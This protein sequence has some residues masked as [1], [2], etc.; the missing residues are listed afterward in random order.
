[1]LSSSKLLH[2][3]KP[4]SFR[5]ILELL[6]WHQQP[7]TSHLWWF[8]GLC[9]FQPWSQKALFLSLYEHAHLF[10]PPPS[11]HLLTRKLQGETLLAGEEVCGEL[12]GDGVKGAV[13]VLGQRRA[14]QLPQEHS[15][16][17]GTVP[18]AK[19]IMNFLGVENQE[20][21]TVENI[22]NDTPINRYKESFIKKNRKQKRVW[23]F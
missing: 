13:C 18:Y 1:M 8:E 20:M 9:P 7:K 19:H 3:L 11:F 12:Q 17:V 23:C 2:T 4:D 22:K 15:S 10:S 6:V 5:N 21:Q 16:I 14:A